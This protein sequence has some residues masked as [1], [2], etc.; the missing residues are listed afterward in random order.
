MRR[1]ADKIPRSWV[2]CPECGLAYGF[3]ACRVTINNRDIC[4]KCLVKEKENKD[5]HSLS[6]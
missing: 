2:Y 3:I 1:K 5:T 6:T 4:L